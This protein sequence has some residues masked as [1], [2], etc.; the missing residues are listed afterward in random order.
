MSPWLSQASQSRYTDL[1]SACFAL[2]AMFRRVAL[3]RFFGVIRGVHMMPVGDV[4]VMPS[5]FVVTSFVMFGRFTMMLR[6]KLVVL[7]CVL[8]ML[9]SFMFRHY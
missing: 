5:L 3:A 2:A 7:G 8:V 9:R 6:G 1:G 4:G